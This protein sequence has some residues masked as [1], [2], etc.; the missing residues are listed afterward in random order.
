MKRGNVVREV[1]PPLY[2]LGGIMIVEKLLNFF[3]LRR[4]HYAMPLHHPRA[5]AIFRHHVG[6]LVE[7][8]DQTVRFCAFEAEG[9]KGRMVL[10]HLLST[11]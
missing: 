4:Q 7:H 1:L 6:A 2:V 11:G 10:L 3:L 5:L 8:L 9:G